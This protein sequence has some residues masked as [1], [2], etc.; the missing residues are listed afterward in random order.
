MC[1]R[2]HVRAHVSSSSSSTSTHSVFLPRYDMEKS[3]WDLRE[4]VSMEISRSPDFPLVL[5]SSIT[6]HLAGK[7][8]WKQE[9]RHRLHILRT[10]YLQ[11]LTMQRKG[12][13][14]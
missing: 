8:P 6:S 13:V 7:V 4:R 11:P 2:V 5:Y 9:G 10:H 14:S 1:V 12:V 3:L